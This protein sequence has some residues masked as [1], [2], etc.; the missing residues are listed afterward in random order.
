[1]VGYRQALS[2]LTGGGN[3]RT[4]WMREGDSPRELVCGENVAARAGKP[5][6]SGD[7]GVS[8]LATSGLC[9]IHDG[10]ARFKRNRNGLSPRA[11]PRY[12]FSCAQDSGPRGGIRA[13]RSLC[14][15]RD[16][17]ERGSAENDGAPEEVAHPGKRF[18]G[19]RSSRR[20][21]WSHAVYMA[22]ARTRFQRGP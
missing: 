14:L 19:L 17:G 5:V 18:C 15:N 21:A 11:G 9:R 13:G 10:A 4:R 2:T 22:E 1:M 20:R 16:L 6:R 8:N 3:C 7:E 12:A